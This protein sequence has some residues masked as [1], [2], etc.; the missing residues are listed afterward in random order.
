MR[1][2][3]YPLGLALQRAGQAGERYVPSNTDEHHLFIDSWCRKCTRDRAMREGLPIERCHADES[4]ELIEASLQY[5]PT[6]D[7]FPTE[8][9]INSDGQP[10][11]RHF[12]PLNT[13][14][15]QRDPFT[16]DLFEQ[17]A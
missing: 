12:L 6:E 8:W 2:A 4:C 10:A 9:I 5:A 15:A 1:I 7:G 3:I 17:A 11:C 16:R 13:P 14:P